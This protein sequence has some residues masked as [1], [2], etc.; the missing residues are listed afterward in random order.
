MMK[1]SL[2]LA[3]IVLLGGCAIDELGFPLAD[4][5]EKVRKPLEYTPPVNLP[6]E[7]YTGEIWVDHDGCI[8]LRSGQG[9]WVPQVNQKRI[10][11][12]DRAAMIAYLERSGRT[13]EIPDGE[14]TI[15]ETAFSVEQALDQVGA[16]ETAASDP[17]PT[18]TPALSPAEPETPTQSY[19]Q[20]NVTKGDEVFNAA[21]GR[22]QERQ[23]KIFGSNRK[24]GSIVLGPFNDPLDLQ[25]ALVT[26]WSFGFLDAFTFEN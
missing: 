14:R 22:F 24:S 25:D 19:V 16:H 12:C 11:M 13:D 8:F 5:G 20:V 18:A 21:R 17:A 7:N 1:P 26:A 4:R 2:P 6:P 15:S 23:I 9:E 10:Q 3:L